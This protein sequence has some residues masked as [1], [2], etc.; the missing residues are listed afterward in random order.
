MEKEK[1]RNGEDN[2]EELRTDNRYEDNYYHK[3]PEE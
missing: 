3:M 2:R 1:K